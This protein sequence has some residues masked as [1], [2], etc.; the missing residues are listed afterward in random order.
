MRSLRTE[1]TGTNLLLNLPSG[2]LHNDQAACLTMTSRCCLPHLMPQF[3]TRG[4]GR[5]LD[6][7]TIFSIF[8]STVTADMW[9]LA[10][11]RFWKGLVRAEFPSQMALCRAST[12]APTDGGSRRGG[13]SR[14]GAFSPGFQNPKAIP[15][16]PFPAR[17][18]VSSWHTASLVCL[19]CLGTRML[20]FWRVG[21][22]RLASAKL[23][24]LMRKRNLKHENTTNQTVRWN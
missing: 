17:A 4:L 5:S 16:T 12:A 3:K 11:V 2:Y 1:K 21:V 7:D 24:L 10:L 23:C 13:N 19:F 15:S 14:S 9:K 8:C 22:W 20:C 18:S 6:S